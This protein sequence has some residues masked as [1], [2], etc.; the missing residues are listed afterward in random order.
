MELPLTFDSAVDILR[1]ADE[2]V[3]QKV[4]RWGGAFFGFAEG[5]PGLLKVVGELP[6]L[7]RDVVEVMRRTGS[8]GAAARQGQEA[9]R[10]EVLVAAHSII[11]TSSYFAPLSDR[12]AK[13]DKNLR[14]SGREALHLSSRASGNKAPLRPVTLQALRSKVAPYPQPHLSYSDLVNDC[15]EFYQ[16]L[17]RDVI[18]FLAGLE[19]W[20]AL[21]EGDRSAQSA[22][23]LEKLP[24]IATDRYESALLHL[25]AAAPEFL[26]WLQFQQQ[27]HLMRSLEELA[28]PDLRSLVTDLAR[29]TASTEAGMRATQDALLA[30]RPVV[31]PL[32]RSVDRLAGLNRRELDEPL[33]PLRDSNELDITPPSLRSAYQTPGY[34]LSSHAPG[35][36]EADDSWWEDQ[37]LR[38]GL[39]AFLVGHLKHPVAMRTPLV[40]LGR[41]GAGK[42]VWCRV[43]AARL[44]DSE[45]LAL[46]I[47][48]RDVHPGS[49]ILEQVE[50]QLRLSLGR[51]TAWA[52]FREHLG[53][54]TPVLLFDGLDEYLLVTQRQDFDYL[55][56]VR[57]FQQHWGALGLPTAA[58]VTSRTVVA[59]RARIP[60][61]SYVIRLE[62]FSEQQVEGWVSAWNESSQQHRTG[63]RNREALSASTILEQGELAREPVLL[64]MLAIFYSH[65]GSSAHAGRLG[66]RAEFYERLLTS[67]LSREVAR[68]AAGGPADRRR[69]LIEL[70]FDQLGITSLAMFNL[71][72]QGAY[73]EE[74]AAQLAIV[75]RSGLLAGSDD[76]Q[77]EPSASETVTALVSSFFFIHESRT[78]E[79]AVEG[80]HGRYYEF[81]HPTFAEYLLARWVAR[82]LVAAQ[83][84]VRSREHPV[85]EFASTLRGLLG[86]SLLANR[87]Q[88]LDFFE[89]IVGTA[90]LPMDV[91]AVR[92]WAWGELRQVASGRLPPVWPAGSQEPVVV[93]RALVLYSA[94]VTFMA[95]RLPPKSVLLSDVVGETPPDAPWQ[96]L[97]NFWKGYMPESDWL[98][99][100]ATHTV[101]QDDEG[102]LTLIVRPATGVVRSTAAAR[103]AAATLAL[104]QPQA[105]LW[106]FY[107]YLQD[108][109]GDAVAKALLAESPRVREAAQLSL[110]ASTRN[111]LTDVWEPLR[112]LLGRAESEEDSRIIKGLVN[113]VTRNWRG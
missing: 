101:E 64:L 39:E 75:R 85:G 51:P 20:Q 86:R 23:I 53:A 14:L 45:Y 22:D 82:G 71:G 31:A 69:Q 108:N 57:D 70:R 103:Q 61:G 34:R 43:W 79:G 1:R 97:V 35:S 83:A 48:L 54:V 12:L 10:P 63:H 102:Q 80:Q 73:H 29:L 40:V 42:S 90:V 105:R 78:T 52:D 46:R 28:S 67:F 111:R 16:L 49:S 113:L 7:R 17:G 76:G 88:V 109:G 66:T 99:L 19:S 95:V 24:P 81:V 9:T 60:L 112:E 5:V 6:R 13:I 92:A 18:R 47:V 4:A 32:E 91:P 74:V 59:A 25:C 106:E 77:P 110:L 21:P 37:P 96:R 30:L 2:P 3:A 11:V 100:G 94:N 65:Q 55:E 41:P 26:L 98:A 89:E 68:A 62:P 8:P 50:Q 93:M 87:P 84:A 104:D 38:A 44:A 56:R 33:L 15:R 72:R 58:V 107:S 27:G 36:L